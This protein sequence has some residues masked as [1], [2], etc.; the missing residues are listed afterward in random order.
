MTE[1]ATTELNIVAPWGVASVQGA[2][3]LAPK[4]RSFRQIFGKSSEAIDDF[5]N[6]PSRKQSA[7]AFKFIGD[8]W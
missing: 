6:A 3:S 2:R 8:V 4:R 1:A 5:E 7:G